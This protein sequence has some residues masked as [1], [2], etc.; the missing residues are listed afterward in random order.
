MNPAACAGANRKSP[1]HPTALAGRRAVCRHRA[2]SSGKRADGTFVLL[3]CVASWRLVVC[4]Q[5]PA[6]SLLKPV[7]PGFN[8]VAHPPRWNSQ[9]GRRRWRSLSKPRIPPGSA[10]R[11]SSRCFF[12]TG[13]WPL[14]QLRAAIR[15]R[16]R[17]MVEHGVLPCPAAHHRHSRRSVHRRLL[18]CR[19]AVVLFCADRLIR[20]KKISWWLPTVLFA[21]LSAVTNH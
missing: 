6:S 12:A 21:A 17:G 20:T 5:T 10:G 3:S 16:A 19:H 4:A 14:F 1:A 9:S 11:I 15:R 18:S 8:A 7:M 2:V 13:L